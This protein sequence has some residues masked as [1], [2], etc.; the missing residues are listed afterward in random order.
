MKVMVIVKATKNSEAGIMPDT[1]LLT[2]MGKY[3]QSLAEA[4][5]LVGGE[6]LLP[7]SRGKR[8]TIDSGGRS[9]ADGPFANASDLVAG[10]WI[11]KV[12]SLEE[13]V[14]WAK[15]CP[16]PMP[17]EQSVLEIRPIIS[18]EDLGD[19]MTPVLREQESR[20]RSDLEKGAAS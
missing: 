1:E 19:A 18:M 11:W 10:F 16:A 6:G 5:V 2:A 17:G 4:G 15:R 7:S 12:A 20:L 3:N 9:V 14:D 13:A 8:V